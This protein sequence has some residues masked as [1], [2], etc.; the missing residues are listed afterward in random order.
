LKLEAGGADLT[1]CLTKIFAVSEVQASC[2]SA[3]R[4]D[5]CVVFLKLWRTTKSW[6]AL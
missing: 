5:V 3:R 6:V 4:I 2:L 1:C